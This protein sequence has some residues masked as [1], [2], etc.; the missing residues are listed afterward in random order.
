M[1]RG[2]YRRRHVDRDVCGHPGANPGGRFTLHILRGRGGARPGH[3]VV[4]IHLIFLRSVRPGTSNQP[5]AMV[6]NT[7]VIIRRP[8]KNKAKI[9]D[10]LARACNLDCHANVREG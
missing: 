9:A 2:W 7:S 4:R 5:P 1:G 10:N 3:G 6:S 8:K